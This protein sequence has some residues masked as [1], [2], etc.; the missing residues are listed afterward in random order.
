MKTTRNLLRHFFLP[1]LGLLSL[2]I[3]HPA[4]ARSRVGDVLI[5]NQAGAPC[6]TIPNTEESRL[7][8][9]LLFYGLSIYDETQPDKNQRLWTL[10]LNPG[11]TPPLL[12]STACYRY[13][14]TATDTT[15]H[16]TTV[17]PLVSGRIYRVLLSARATDPTDP[18][19]AYTAR[20]CLI[21]QPDGS[22]DV[23]QIQYRQGWHDEPCRIKPTPSTAP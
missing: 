10:R 1:L 18:T 17:P 22:H 23:Y 19:I 15:A 4:A 2:A 7:N 16:P 3:I 9:D 6:F 12:H 13:G 11:S 8:G 21:T 14:V 20:F 5:Q